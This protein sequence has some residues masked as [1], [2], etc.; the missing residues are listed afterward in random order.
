M[1][2]VFGDV[3][4]VPASDFTQSFVAGSWTAQLA[5]GSGNVVSSCNAT[6]YRNRAR[7]AIR[8][9][10]PCHA[11]FGRRLYSCTS[12]AKIESQLRPN[13]ANQDM[14]S[15]KDWDNVSSPWSKIRPAAKQTVGGANAANCG[16]A[17]EAWAWAIRATFCRERDRS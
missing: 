2:C 4:K 6:C 13:A 12:L 3:G 11:L 8:L 7:A 5:A 15:Q 16:L 17:R 1:D 14:L 10:S 9:F